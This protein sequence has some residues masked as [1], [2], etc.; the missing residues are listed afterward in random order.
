MTKL[1]YL[2]FP[3]T[4]FA[5]SFNVATYNVYNL[6]DDI[7]NH[8]EYKD[9][10]SPKWNE[11]DFKQKLQKIAKVIK[12]L[13]AHIIAL[14]EIENENALLHLK[15]NLPFYKYHAFTLKKN[16]AIGLALLSKYPIVKTKTVK[17]TQNTRDILR[18]TLNINNH[19]INIYVNHWPSLNNDESKRV[20][21][22]NAL[23][24][25]IATS[26]HEYIITGDLNSNYNR[27]LFYPA[28]TAINETIKSVN[29]H[30]PVFKETI[31]NQQ[32]FNLWLDV[33]DKDRF[34]YFYRGRKNTL[35]H[36]VLPLAMFD[37][38]GIDYVN[39]SFKVFKPSYLLHNNKIN[40]T[41][42]DHLPLTAT[43]STRPFKMQQPSFKHATIGDLTNDSSKILIKNA[44]ITYVDRNGFIIKDASKKAIFVYAP[45]IDLKPL[46]SYDFLVESTKIYHEML[47]VDSFLLY[48]KGTKKIEN[49]F[50]ERDA[51]INNDKYLHEVFKQVHGTYFNDKFYYNDTF[52]NIYFQDRSKK[53]AKEGEITLKN[54][55]VAKYKGK[56]QLVVSNSS[57]VKEH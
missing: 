25:D 44:M 10:L 23:M 2:L 31:Q 11:N 13:N 57:E 53:P 15:N 39:N 24:R 36:I 18:V 45:K 1:L 26:T 52:I 28:N 33:E 55:R 29:N 17:V 5:T 3:L 8:T 51:V 49:I 40:K 32:H 41:Y 48:A 27:Y 54:V 47:E 19:Y 22:A 12:D 21:S 14:Q 38:K 50:L 56:L 16:S 37:K 42:S 4:L 30:I 43:F 9:F 46:H 35:D 7:D 20:A 6:F 34:S